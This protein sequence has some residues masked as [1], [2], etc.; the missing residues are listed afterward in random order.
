MARLANVSQSTVSLVLNNVGDNRFTEETRQRVLAAAEQL[1]YVPHAMARSLRAGHSNLVLLP[2]FDLTYQFQ[3]LRS[4][5]R[6]S[7]CAWMSW[8]IRCCCK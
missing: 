4:S 3:R 1:G 5:S 2:F 6:Q 8:A 7:P